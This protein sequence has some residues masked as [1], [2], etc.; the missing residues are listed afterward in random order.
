MTN[1]SYPSRSTRS[2]NP[3]CPFPTSH[4]LQACPRCPRRGSLAE[5]QESF[6]RTRASTHHHRAQGIGLVFEDGAHLLLIYV[7]KP[8]DKPIGRR[9]TARFSFGAKSRIRAPA[10]DLSRYRVWPSKPPE[11]SCLAPEPGDDRIRCLECPCQS[12]MFGEFSPSE[13]SFIGEACPEAL[14]QARVDDS[15][16]QGRVPP[17]PELSSGTVRKPEAVSDGKKGVV[18]PQAFESSLSVSGRCIDETDRTRANRPP[19]PGGS[20]DARRRARRLGPE[21]LLNAT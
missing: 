19:L 7:G 8:L 10:D 16:H 14:P 20:L 12:G 13:P 3:P 17:A 15:R 1:T 6:D 21:K 4:S 5:A 9:A 18:C 11:T 2:S